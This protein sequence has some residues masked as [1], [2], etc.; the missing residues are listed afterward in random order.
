MKI[1]TLTS[2]VVLGGLVTFGCL[3]TNSSSAEAQVNCGSVELLGNSLRTQIIEQINDQ[4]AGE[5][6]RINRRKTLRINRIEDITFDGCQMSVRGN[7]TLQRRIRRDAHGTVDLQANIT[8]LN[9]PEQAFCYG[10]A[11]VADVSLS[12]TLNIGEAVYRWV[13]NKALPDSQC[14]DF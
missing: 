7:V 4:V 10:D 12:R 6:H 9:L 13:A 11:R 14:F 5:S 3:F 2:R 1:N 8:S